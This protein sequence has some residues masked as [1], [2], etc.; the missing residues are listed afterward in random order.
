M[1]SIRGKDGAGPTLNR[2]PLEYAANLQKSA[3]TEELIMGSPYAPAGSID[4]LPLRPRQ[5]DLL[6][7]IVPIWTN[8]KS[9]S[10]GLNIFICTSNMK[11]GLMTAEALAEACGIRVRKFP[12]KKL[13]GSSVAEDDKLIDPITQRKMTPFDYAFAGTVGEA[14]MTL[15][16]DDEGEFDAALKLNKNSDT[17]KDLFLSKFITKL[18]DHDGFTCTVSPAVHLKKLPVEFHLNLILEH[19]PEEMQICGWETHLGNGSHSDEELVK[20]V[21]RHPMHIA[22]IDQIAQRAR[23]RS[24]VRGG[25]DE[26]TLSDI[27]EVIAEYHTQN[28]APLLFGRKG[29]AI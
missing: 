4:C 10:E 25:K 5:K 26:V 6:K 18:R 23:I 8:E 7:R 21:E 19:P 28:D 1:K 13:L 14:C 29:G 24:F 12:L 9:K 17:S 16:S 22:E 15:F 20:L 27:Y 3:L 11:V 2:D